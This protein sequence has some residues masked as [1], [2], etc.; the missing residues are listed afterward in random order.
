MLTDAWAGGTAQPAGRPAALVQVPGLLQVQTA[1]AARP[2][3]VGERAVRARPARPR[4]PRDTLAKF[5]RMKLVRTCSVREDR[6]Q[7]APAPRAAT[8]WTAFRRGL[9]TKGLSGSPES[10][11]SAEEALR[12]RGAAAGGCASGRTSSCAGRSASSST[13]ARTA[14][15]PRA[16]WKPRLEELHGLQACVLSDS[17]P[18]CTGRPGAARGPTRRQRAR[19]APAISLRAAPTPARAAPQAWRPRAFSGLTGWLK[20]DDRGVHQA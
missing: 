16:R 3:A 12:A 4:P 17:Q 20:P 19:C 18:A 13:S 14:A 11:G 10:C 9:S 1:G 7:R 2:G 8:V 6:G 15:R 5:A